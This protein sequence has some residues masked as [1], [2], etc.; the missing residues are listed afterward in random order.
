MPQLKDQ[1]GLTAKIVDDTTRLLRYKE[2]KSSVPLTKQDM[3]NSD[4]IKQLSQTIITQATLIGSSEEMKFL[5]EL[6]L[7]INQMKVSASYQSELKSV[8]QEQEALLND[9]NE[10]MND[11][12]EMMQLD[13]ESV[14]K[15]HDKLR[16]KIL[17]KLNQ[18]MSKKLEKLLSLLLNPKNK[19]SLRD[20]LRK[21]MN[22]I[23]ANIER[24]KKNKSLDKTVRPLNEDIYINLFGL[25]N[26][27][28]TGSIPVPLSQYIGN[29][30]GFND[31]N[32]HHGYAN[33]DKINELNFMF[34]D[35]LGME[36]DTLRNF[37]SI[38]DD[39]VNELTDLLRAEGLAPE[40]TAPTPF[41]ID[42]GPSTH[43]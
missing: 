28:I 8:I 16:K 11:L 30:L 17:K 15:I 41:A 35:S 13:P 19:M 22:E 33:I 37:L 6:I 34:G 14:N 24:L 32:P 27:Y 40:P 43:Q 23:R 36:S 7:A 18:K 25:L 1:H 29:G 31:W 3:M 9:L 21:L 39:V 5:E 4:F 10:I 42:K 2:E 12:M 26:S 38:E 20:A